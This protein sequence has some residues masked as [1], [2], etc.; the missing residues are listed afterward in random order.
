MS[1]SVV[2]YVPGGSATTPSLPGIKYTSGAVVQ[3]VA[4]NKKGAG[5]KVKYTTRT[6]ERILVSKKQKDH[7]DSLKNPNKPK[8]KLSAKSKAKINR[9]LQSRYV[10]AFGVPPVYAKESAAWRNRAKSSRAYFVAHPAPARGILEQGRAG[11]MAHPQR[12]HRLA[13]EH[14]DRQTGQVYYIPYKKPPSRKKG[15]IEYL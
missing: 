1:V 3:V 10:A 11:S 7:Y 14:Y 6:G 15:E 13:I 5:R 2:P 12:A 8:S 9:G 4:K